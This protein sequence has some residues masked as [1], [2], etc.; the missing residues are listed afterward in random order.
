MTLSEIFCHNFPSIGISAPHYSPEEISRLQNLLCKFVDE[1]SLFNKR[2]N[3]VAADSSEQIA[4]NHVLDCLAAVPILKQ[5]IFL[6]KTEIKVADLGSGAGFPG[7]PL[8][9][10]FPEIKWTLV[11]RMV[12][13]S[14][15]LQGTV[16]QLGLKNV[17]VFQGDFAD[18]PAETFDF[19]TFRA[20]HPFEESL[21]KNIFRLLKTHGTVLAYK[22]K[23]EKILEEMRDFPQWVS[24]YKIF[25]LKCDFL[26]DHQR[27]LV[28]FKKNV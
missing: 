5:K 6:Q 12:K 3:L 9:A 10:A 2:M 21:L 7:I 25:P 23:T 27:N 4:K 8:A 20:F 13:R 17:E 19:A 24:N 18:V 15:F 1:I 26:P 11:E 14:T 22:A 28:V 16:A